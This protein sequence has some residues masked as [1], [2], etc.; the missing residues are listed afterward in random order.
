MCYELEDSRGFPEDIEYLLCRIDH[1][2][3]TARNLV[4][5]VRFMAGKRW[6]HRNRQILPNFCCHIAAHLTAHYLPKWLPGANFRIVDGFWLSGA[7]SHSWL[8]VTM[9]NPKE[10]KKDFD[11]I[12]DPRPPFATFPTVFDNAVPQITAFLYNEKNLDQVEFA[13]NGFIFRRYI[14]SLVIQELKRLRYDGLKKSKTKFDKAS[15]KKILDKL[16]KYAP[17]E[18]SA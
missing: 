17:R 14:S 11:F 15:Y 8:H 7:V 16:L 1:L 5:A 12:L 18:V 13:G 6:I 3:Y 2:N 9:P 4:W 10:G